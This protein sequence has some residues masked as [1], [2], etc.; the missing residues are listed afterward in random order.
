[1]KLVLLTCSVMFAA[2]GA[3][4]WERQAGFV[5]VH[6]TL[7]R[8]RGFDV[9]LGWGMV[10]SMVDVAEVLAKPIASH[11][12]RIPRRPRTPLPEPPMSPR[13]VYDAMVRLGRTPGCTQA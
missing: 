1:M 7:S 5:V 4:R 10:R 12:S 6:S 11:G 3:R 9:G 13:Q 8:E 2:S